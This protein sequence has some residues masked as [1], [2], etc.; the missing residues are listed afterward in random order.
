[1]KKIT[2]FLM[3]AAALVGLAGCMA[4]TTR[5]SKN[6]SKDFQ[7]GQFEAIDISGN[8][9]VYYSQ[10]EK[11]SVRAEGDE[12]LVSSLDIGSDGHTLVIAQKPYRLS[13]SMLRKSVALY[14]TSP[15][16]T[17]VNMTGNGD[18][19]AEGIVDTD[20]L[21]VQLTGNGDIDFQKVICDKIFLSLTGNGDIEVDDVTAGYANIRLTGN[22]DVEI[23]G[24]VGKLDKEKLGNGDIKTE[25]LNM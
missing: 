18:F 24:R 19:K 23:A 17:S 14:V 10:G 21:R 8:I 12:M 20:E 13:F 15:D 2:M 4:Q 5:K 16:L 22:G 7:P 3:A 9:D 1:M 11:I 25:G 6:V